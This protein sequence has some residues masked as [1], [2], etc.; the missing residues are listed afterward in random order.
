M[1]ILIAILLLL[2]VV[3]FY[4]GIR[5][6][7]K[8][9]ARLEE[10]FRKDAE[11]D[12][13]FSWPP[14]PAEKSE[15]EPKPEPDEDSMRPQIIINLP[16]DQVPMTQIPAEVGVQELPE[17][18]IAPIEPAEMRVINNE[19]AILYWTIFCKACSLS[20]E[21]EPFYDVRPEDV[22]AEAVVTVY[23]RLPEPTR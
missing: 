19:R 5:W 15:P 17:K 9:K 8:L 20:E 14:P 16:K 3:G 23:G 4:L 7:L 2:V 1:E 6:I 10:N 21:G 12:L 13:K 18:I 11:R 22:A